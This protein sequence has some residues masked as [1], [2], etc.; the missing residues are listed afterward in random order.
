MDKRAI[1]AAV[2]SMAVLLGYQVFYINPHMEARRAAKEKAQKLA[3]ERAGASGK[4]DTKPR[5]Q[6]DKPPIAL[7]SPQTP[8]TP[9]SSV[10]KNITVDTGVAHITFTTLGAGLKELVLRDYRDSKGRPFN[11]IATGKGGEGEDGRTRGRTQKKKWRPLYLDGGNLGRR[12]NKG[13]YT[14]SR[15]SL[16]LTPENPDGTLEFIY[17][18][19]SGTAVSKTLRFRHGSYAFDAE[20]RWQGAG[21][22]DNEISIVWGPGITTEGRENDYYATTGPVTYRG[23]KLVFPDEDD[24]EE[25]KPVFQGGDIRWTSLQSKYFMAALIPREPRGGFAGASIRDDEG[26][27]VGL[28]YRGGPSG[29]GRLSLF[30][31]P[32]DERILK[33]HEASLTE[34]ID[35]GFFSFLAK[36]LL[37]ALRFF[38]GLTGSYGLAIILITLAIKIVFYPLTQKS[39]RSMKAMQKLQPKMKQVREIF[40]DDRQRM[41]E[42]VMKLYRENKANPLGGCLPML[43]QVPVFFALYNALMGSIDLRQAP[44]LWM[45][46]LSA[47]ETGLF[48]IPGIGV[49]FRILVLLMGASMFLQQKMTPAAGDPM[50]Q[51]MMLFMPIFFTFLFWSFPGGLVVYW[52]TNNILTI[53]QQYFT[54]REPGKPKLANE[55][56]PA[57]NLTAQ[58]PVEKKSGPQARKKSTKRSKS[59]K[60]P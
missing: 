37:V 5:G 41:N 12:A 55:A 30:A 58:K 18:S 13:I 22:E 53:V 38:Y 15:E 25:G 26:M 52:F 11:L 7:K 2:L 49:E 3:A 6:Q 50:Q 19:S 45:S 21:P 29:S 8:T 31:G 35:L 60:K 23:G 47:P 42:E 33:A 34:A 20:I 44:F 9:E 27:L 46:D 14:V 51:K 36:P 56:L 32:K 28:R 17:R 24:L 1:L 40:K 4:I 48:V 59:G 43:L 39:T 54:L 57:K 10:A 16:V